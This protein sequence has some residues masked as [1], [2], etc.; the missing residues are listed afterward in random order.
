MMRTLSCSCLLVAL[1]LGVYLWVLPPLRPKSGAT[2]I[3]A[4]AVQPIQCETAWDLTP[5]V[6]E[7]SYRHESR[8]AL[9]VF[10]P[11]REQRVWMV[12]DGTTLYVDRNGNGDLTEPDERLEP[13]G[14]RP[15]GNPGKYTHTDIFEFTVHTGATSTSKF[16][17]D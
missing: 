5:P 17:L 13:N 4:P 7:P 14:A 1:G 15:F 16:R 10:G 3:A 12:L 8:Y 11:K 6:K 2:P 9:L